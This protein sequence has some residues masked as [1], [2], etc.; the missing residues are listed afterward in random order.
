MDRVLEAWQ[1]ADALAQIRPEHREVIVETYYGGCS[2]NQA[3]A[4]LGV[5]AGTVKSR[6]FYGLRAM[7]LALEEMGVVVT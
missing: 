5:P 4:K 7:R 6:L 1:V 2:V 3:A